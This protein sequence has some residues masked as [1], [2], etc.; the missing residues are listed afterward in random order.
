MPGFPHA[1]K[2]SWVTSHVSWLNITEVVPEMSVIFNH[3]AL[4]M[5]TTKMIPVTL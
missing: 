1:D 2:S 4:L 5:G 3:Q